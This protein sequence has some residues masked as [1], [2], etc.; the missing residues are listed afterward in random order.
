MV[1]VVRIKGQ[2]EQ[3]QVGL[4]NTVCRSQEKF[5]GRRGLGCGVREG[6]QASLSH[7]GLN[8]VLLMIRAKVQGS[9]DLAKWLS[10]G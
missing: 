6:R 4:I 1:V 8:G 5:T 3:K 9:R 2:A 10:G 7:R